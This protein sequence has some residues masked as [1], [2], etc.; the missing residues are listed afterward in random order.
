MKISVADVTGR[1]IRTIEGTKNAGLNRVQWDLTPTPPPRVE[2]VARV[3]RPRQ[4]LQPVARQRRRHQQV[5]RRLLGLRLPVPPPHLQRRAG[6]LLLAQQRQARV[7][8]AGAA[9][10]VAASFSRSRRA[11]I[12]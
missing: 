9:V 4:H 1:E 2:D 5:R 3:R 6:L 10:A 8:R 7:D 12:W 11:R